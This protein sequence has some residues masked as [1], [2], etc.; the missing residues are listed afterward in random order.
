MATKEE[1][2]DARKLAELARTRKPE[3][4]VE[5]ILKT[6]ERQRVRG[7]IQALDSILSSLPT[8]ILELPDEQ[9]KVIAAIVTVIEGFHDRLQEAEKKL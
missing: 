8:R 1:V 5:A 6:M 4:I 7:G 9:R 3:I 2:A